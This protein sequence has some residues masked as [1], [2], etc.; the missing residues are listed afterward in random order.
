MALYKV[1][2][3]NCTLGK[4]NETV[5]IDEASGL[6]V[7]ALIEGAHIQAVVSNTSKKEQEIKEN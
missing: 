3:E 1:L 5:S 2:T 6:N 7:E 4:L